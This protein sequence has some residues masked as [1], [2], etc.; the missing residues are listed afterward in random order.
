MDELWM[1]VGQ[2]LLAA[3]LVTALAGAATALI[4]ILGGRVAI[5]W[6]RAMAWAS[7]G[8][9]LAASALLLALILAQ[10]YDF[11]YVYQYT[12]QDL[13][14]A[15]R[16]SAFW[17]GQP[18]SFLLWLLL[19][20]IFTVAQ[21]RRA[22]QLEPYVLFFLLLV[23]AGLA[24][25]MLVDVPAGGSVLAD[26]FTVGSGPFRLLGVAAQD[27]AGLN[28][29][30]QNP[31]M[32]AHP[33]VLFLGYAGLA[34][35]CAYAL[36]A[37]WRRDYD[38][39]IRP[40]L[41]AALL[42]WLFLGLGIYLGAYWSYETLGWGGYWGWD[43]VENSSALPWFTATALVH[44]LVAQRYRQRLRHASFPLAVGTFLLILLAT[45]L[46]RSGVLSQ[47]SSHAFAEGSLHPW[48][49][50]LQLAAL[51]G[52]LF[53]IISRWSDIPGNPAAGVSTE[54]VARPRGGRSWLSRDLAMVVTILILLLLAAVI[55]LGTL[56]PV[57]TRLVGPPAPVDPSFYP[58]FTGPLLAVLL[59]VL[60]L[61]PLL[62]WERSDWRDLVR[63]LG[64]AAGLAAAALVLGVVLGVRSPAAMLLIF[65]GVHAL[66]VN[67]VVLVRLLR[68]GPLRLGGYLA[69]VGLG[70]LVVGIV[71]SSMY[72]SDELLQLEQGRPQ[73]A[74]GYQVRFVGW[75]ES[76]GEWPALRLELT[77]G[78]E[79]LIS[80]PGLFADPQDRSTIATPDVRRYL[81]HDLYISAEGYEAAAD[82]AELILVQGG[83]AAAAGYSLTLQSIISATPC[84]QVVVLVDAP[85]LHRTVTP[86]AGMAGTAAVGSPAV[87][88]DGGTV[89]VED[90]IPF[91]A[92][93]PA[94]HYL[95]LE[96]QP[97]MIGDYRVTLRDLAMQVQDQAGGTVAAAAVLDFSGP[98]G[99]QVITAT[100]VA[101]ADQ[102]ASPPEPLFPRATVR[103]VRISVGQE[104]HSVVLAIDGPDLPRQQGA[105]WLLVSSAQSTGLAYVRL[106][107]K[108]GMSLLWG[109]GLVL[110]LGTALAVVRR[111]VEAE[112]R[113]APSGSPRDRAD[114]LS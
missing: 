50:G 92:E 12:S 73:E 2:L 70:L 97:A 114:K 109:G 46:T 23:Q 71:A 11:A 103:L 85:G 25:L 88:P 52:S 66:A 110:L 39:W 84:Y 90:V 1:V 47:F 55:L 76:P 57:L 91:G 59:V 67:A 32:V 24:L 94:D 62:G 65:L 89:Q 5:A 38:A 60:T 96:G 42:G 34:V 3:G 99:L 30:L 81:T 106:S 113:R 111:A 58:L 93:W 108:P 36:A 49:V 82:E 27:G 101:G 48:M 31:W 45:Y 56:S 104:P 14:P 102:L 37:L 72:G 53:L 95:L 87:L 33:P 35:P 100:Q 29:L 69:H 74:M 22:R 63:I 28:P 9:A 107:V 79:T 83:L 6:T 41:P 80:L 4:V 86:T 10:R 18:G 19:A 26:L 54:E 15:Y 40:A 68:A 98:A 8:L 75:Q 78:D 105:A 112:G 43:P 21:V 64:A 13:A 7:F 51:G 16:V 61:C 17:A 44:G 77:R 20:S